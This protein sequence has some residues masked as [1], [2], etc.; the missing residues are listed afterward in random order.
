MLRAKA[1][2]LLSLHQGWQWV[3]PIPAPT[4]M[5]GRADP[6]MLSTQR[7]FQAQGLVGGGPQ[8][9]DRHQNFQLGAAVRNGRGWDKDWWV[10]GTGCP[11]STVPRSQD[12][13]PGVAGECP[14]GT[15]ALV[16]RL[17][18]LGGRVSCFP[19][20]SGWAL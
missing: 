4:Q 9:L 3:Y 6:W 10:E 1:G 7:A 13:G 19:I 8:L 2:Q 14:G 11:Q 12:L 15:R 5:P 16:R 20:A 18:G 17:M